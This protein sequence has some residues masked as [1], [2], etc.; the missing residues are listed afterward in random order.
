MNETEAAIN[1]MLKQYGFA[2][3]IHEAIDTVGRAARMLAPN[4]AESA[5]DSGNTDIRPE[6]RTRSATAWDLIAIAHALN[7]VSS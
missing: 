4:V 2:G 1:E 7:G 5:M 6:G 3:G